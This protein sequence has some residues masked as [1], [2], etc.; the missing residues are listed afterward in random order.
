M[1]SFFACS[2]GSSI[3]SLGKTKR[4]SPYGAGIAAG[5]SPMMWGDV[6]DDDDDLAGKSGGDHGQLQMAPPP[7]MDGGIDDMD[8]IADVYEP[9][10]IMSGDSTG[11]KGGG[12]YDAP[13]SKLERPSAR[14]PQQLG[15]EGSPSIMGV[16]V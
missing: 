4:P 9:K 16:N 12:G 5:K 1:E 2:D 13:V 8:S 7:M 15:G 3:G 6:D 14:R 11:S 10:P